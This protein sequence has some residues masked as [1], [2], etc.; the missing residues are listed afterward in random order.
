MKEMSGKGNLHICHFMVLYLEDMKWIKALMENWRFLEMKTWK[1]LWVK[2]WTNFS[3]LDKNL[4]LET[5]K[6]RNRVSD[7]SLVAIC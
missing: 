4:S 5:K 2:I 7:R 6:D 1:T 3:K